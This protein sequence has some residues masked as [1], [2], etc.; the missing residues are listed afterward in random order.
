MGR[1]ANGRLGN[2]VA[3]TAV[4]L[5]VVLDGILLVVTALG[6]LGIRLT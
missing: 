5:V 2:V 1:H 6:A 4:G 3:W